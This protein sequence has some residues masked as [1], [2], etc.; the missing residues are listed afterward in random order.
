MASRFFALIPALAFLAKGLPL[1]HTR[2]GQRRKSRTDNSHAVG[3]AR[4]AGHL[5]RRNADA[6]AAAGPVRQQARPHAGGSG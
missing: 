6:A 3:R 4:P 5:E 2:S 1:P